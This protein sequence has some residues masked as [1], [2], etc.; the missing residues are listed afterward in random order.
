[1]N[2]SAIILAGGRSK[3]LGRDKCLVKIGGEQSILRVIERVGQV[4]SEVLVV[5]AANHPMPVL[6][7]QEKVRVMVDRF[8]DKGALG[9][10]YTGLE[11]STSIYSLVVGC[12]MPFLNVGLLRHLVESCMS[13]DVL[14][15]RFDGYCEPLH[16]VYSK[17]CLPAIE[18]MLGMGNLKILSFFPYVEVKYL[19]E[20][21]ID[22]FD[23]R[24]QSFFNI[25]TEED[26][27]RADAIDA[28]S[29]DPGE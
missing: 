2:T 19:E 4:A 11:A 26:V 8:P 14:I 17:S 10:L 6:E 15:P 18:K 1:M 5:T 21:E 3:R 29:G 28:E 9:G 20:A 27:R 12:D 13:S 25:N 24:R 16:A 23:P 22:S 7:G